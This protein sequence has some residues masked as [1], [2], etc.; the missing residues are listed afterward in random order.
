MRN[1]RQILTNKKQKIP[2]RFILIVPFIIQIGGAVGFTAYF[3]FSHGHDSIEKLAFQLL[4]RVTERVR[5]RLN[6]YLATPHLINQINR[7]AIEANHINPNNLEQI[8]NHFWDQIQ[9]FDSISAISMSNEKGELIEYARLNQNNFYLRIL[10]K[11]IS[12]NRQDY[13]VDKQ[14]NPIKL[15]REISNYAPRQLS[16]YQK[17]KEMG[18]PTWTP[19]YAGVETTL[20]RLGAV[21]PIYDKSGKLNH[22]FVVK[23][24]LLEISQFLKSLQVSPRGQV[25]I[26]ETTGELVASSTLEKPFIVSAD[27]KT[28]TRVNTLNSQNFFTSLIT[29][30][31]F[32]RLGK[33]DKIQ[34]SKS[35]ELE[36]NN[37][38][39]Y[40]QITPYQD[41][42]G[43]NWL[44]VVVVPE[45]DFMAEIDAHTHQTILWCILALIIATGCGILTSKWVTKPISKLTEVTVK[46]ATGNFDEIIG[47]DS[48]ILE[49]DQLA[50]AFAEMRQK[51]QDYFADLHQL[52]ETLTQK[53]SQL[54]QFLDALPVGFIVYTVEGKVNYLN[55]RGIT[56]MKCAEKNISTLEDISTICPLYYQESNRNYPPEKMPCFSALKGEATFIDD[57]EVEI[58]NQ[59]IPLEIWA[60]PIYKEG[61]I[62]Y[63]IAVFQDIT[64]RKKAEK[65]LSEYN[66]NLEKEVAERTAQLEKRESLLRS[67]GDNL[68]NGFIYQ[69]VMQNNGNIHFNYISAGVEKV[70]GV[71]AEEALQNFHLLDDLFYPDDR[72][73]FDAAFDESRKN[74]TVFD[75]S[76][77]KQ[78]PSGEI[79]W[80][81]VHSVPR[82][83]DDGTIIWDGIELDI[84]ALKHAEEAL[85]DSQIKLNHILD[86]AI[87]AIASIRVYEDAPCK[88]EYISAG[89]ELIF[90]YTTQELKDDHNVW[91]SGIHP[92]DKEGFISTFYQ[93]VFAE[94][95]ITQEYRFYHKDGSLRWISQPLTSH[96]DSSTDSWLV[97]LV[98]I[99]ISS[100][101]S[102][103][104]ALAESKTKLNDILDSA[105]SAISNYRVYADY[106]WHY[107]YFSAGQEI[108]FGYT[109]QELIADQNLWMSRVYPEDFQNVI[110]PNF[111][112]I[113][114]GNTI[115][116]QFRFYH[117]DGSLRWISQTLASRYDNIDDCWI[118][119]TVANDISEQKY[120]EIALQ[121]SE[122]KLND[123]LDNTIAA[124]TTFRAYPDYTFEY[125][126]FSAGQ[127]AI[128]GYTARD[129][130]ADKNLWLSRIYPEDVEEYIF[131]AFEDI[132]AQRSCYREFRFYHKDGSL[133]WICGNL[134]SRRDPTGNFWIV[135]TVAFDISDR[136]Y[137][138]IA[139]QESEAKISDILNTAIASIVC[140]RVLPDRTL[141]YD[142]RSSGSEKLYGYTREEFLNDP[143]LW[144]NLIFPE[145]REKVIIPCLEEI[146]AQRNITIEFRFY[147]KDGSLHWISSTITSSYIPEGNYWKAIAV[148]TD[149]TKQKQIEE[150]LR[151]REEFL[152]SIY[153]G[154]EEGIFVIAVMENG[155]F[156]FIST[157][158]AYQR[159][160]GLSL[161]LLLGKTPEETGIPDW[162]EVTTRYQ[163][164]R[165][166]G[167]TM[168]YED[169]R[170]IEGEINWFA[171]TITPLRDEKNRISQLIGTTFNTTSI[172]KIESRL[173]E[174]L[175]KLNIHFEN[176][177][178]A[179]IEWDEELRVK[180]WS[181]HAEQIFG[182]KAE[183]VMNCNPFFDWR[184]VYEE[185]EEIVQGISH[186]LQKGI[187]PSKSVEN[188]NYTKDGRVIY[189]E[190]Y[191]SVVCDDTGKVVS[192]LS[193]VED[194][195]QRKD[196][197]EALRQSEERFRSAFDTAPIGMAIVSLEGTLIQ[198]NQPIIKMF[199]YTETEILNLNVVALSY[200]E[201]M[202]KDLSYLH[203]LISGTIPYYHLEKR[204]RHKDGHLLWGHLSVA[205]VR[206]SQQNPLYCVCQVQDIT[207]RKKA[208]DAL[209]ASEDRFER[210]IRGSNDGIWDWF[211]IN[212]EKIW[213]SPRVFEIIGYPAQEFQFT[214][215]KL[216]EL[217]HPQDKER[218]FGEIFDHLYRHIPYEAEYRWQTKSGR[219]IWIGIR[220]QAEWD[221]LGNPLRMAGSITDITAR[222][223]AEIELQ[224]AMLAS[225]A[226]NRAK[227]TFLANMSHELRTPLNAILGFAQLMQGDNQ[228]SE[229]QRKKLDIINRNGEHLLH[230][231]NDVL[232]ISKIEVNQI[233]LQKN[234]FD[235]YQFIEELKQTF[236]FRANAKG[237]SLNFEYPSE[238]PQYIQTDEVKLRQV[239]TNFLD[240]A[241][242]FT[243]KGDVT[244]RVMKKDDGGKEKEE[245]GI[246]IISEIVG[247]REVS[248]ELDDRD[249]TAVFSTNE[250]KRLNT[251]TIR[252]NLP[253]SS[254][255]F[256]QF[257]IED[258]GAGISPDELNLLFEPFV[259][260]ESGRTSGQGTGLGLM[261]S[262]RF[263]QL[264]GGDI[265]VE[266]QP[267]KGTIFRFH[268]LI[269]LG[270]SEGIL[271]NQPAK[272]IMGLAPNQP[273]YRILVVEDVAESRQLL[274]DLLTSLGLEVAEAAD[275]ATAVDLWE[276]FA[277]H[278]I[279]MDI[280][281]PVLDGYKATRQIRAHPQGE[282]T[283]IIAI[284]ASVFD[285][286]RQR[287]LAAG[288]NDFV[289][290]P[291]SR[292]V[293]F[294]KLN[295]H[296]GIQYLY[297]DT[298][299]PVE[300][301]CLPTETKIQEGLILMPKKWV[302]DF[303]LAARIAD[304]EEMFELL[305]EI[306]ES[307][308]WLA[309]TLLEL[310]KNFHLDQIIALMGEALQL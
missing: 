89:L 308:D 257:E 262:R 264:M 172:R 15:F 161:E 199:G 134:T 255:L 39:Q 306:P 88:Y 41:Q 309:E 84:T 10:D 298:L 304:Q 244:F 127:E 220:G 118:V 186:R 200:P 121:A 240:N 175:K 273:T 99:D 201:D 210:A 14:G 78:H 258:T 236:L 310:I 274:V 46:I 96:Y 53:E 155:E 76:A 223:I 100:R 55:P 263:I 176:S 123:I 291:F 83:L 32:T 5:D 217:V 103:E 138:E 203:Q 193:F 158:P 162:Q 192:I 19:I 277:P 16:R 136:K 140:F 153:S 149:I 50:E 131:T 242:K 35:V 80:S 42:Y 163:K 3:S 2:L 38:H 183:E 202:E 25:F 68:V 191:N 13:T 206:D 288:C 179:I 29:K 276:N 166:I 148:D 4:D 23:L 1:S 90:G 229:H 265:T 297:E 74:L 187:I 137:L 211:D 195:T 113:F 290:K 241:I 197:E 218:V 31:L 114:A 21:T 307:L 145:D 8:R 209:K 196:A 85:R 60:N 184:F 128:F 47:I 71:N 75:I 245:G 224:H 294:D 91:L 188:R 185:D 73:Q 270:N 40:V 189:T 82:L 33:F 37:E 233:I 77:R 285:E 157:N 272:R 146:I 160:T 256:L 116:Q 150:A 18:K 228:I 24:S 61:E 43:L 173:E 254:P 239:L 129:F 141:Q 252:D 48:L 222:K 212:Q 26:I 177:P 86:S 9:L 28:V 34:T 259:Q 237:I 142:Y 268:I 225:E 287:I 22:V 171:S 151:E 79:R 250:S 207:E 204:Y 49:V 299:T 182:W 190:W 216:K 248:R 11:K 213:C 120:L 119:T 205:L 102:L 109:A 194:I 72:P 303:H 27:G 105:I 279:W 281:L 67:I 208:E 98:S 20:P 132:F 106:R 17:A 269:H 247:F 70:S 169:S 289:P 230:L 87:A 168:C 65:L 36:I 62:I 135:T 284:S 174:S 144:D 117:K 226:A 266:S 300:L 122:N 52:N 94:N 221:E 97:I 107:E 215:S 108:I 156:R 164:C 57:V 115:T 92:E 282:N 170:M 292:S 101:K 111:E 267:S 124:I 143:S 95:T 165:E 12:N 293:I 280:R 246:E 7:K 69:L 66:K 44:L 126:Y 93:A 275:G 238:V 178:L 305:K 214:L 249:T 58:E 271:H 251:P 81:H 295:Q 159:I 56:L 243:A 231:I 278:L 301:P 63:G 219:Y 125:E 54:K 6:T 235:F 227:S 296:L 104:I 64:P 260:T 59:R 234:T 45:S 167:Q 112:A 147:H 261:I 110:Q 181:K 30:E 133:R 139:L 302:Q 286:D 51:L 130:M 283:I 152:H 154:V 198:V 180:R 253:P 232:S